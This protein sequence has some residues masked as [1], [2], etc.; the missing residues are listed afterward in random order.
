MKIVP[1]LTAVWICLLTV[2]AAQAQESPYDEPP[3]AEPPYFRIRYMAS[4]EPGKLIFPVAYTVWIPAGV[5]TLRGVVVHQHGCGEGS[6][7]SGQTGAYDLHWQALARKHDCALLSP[8]YEQPEGA[9]CQTWCDPRNGSDTAFQRAL[10]DLGRQ[11]VHEELASVPW[12][13]WGHSGGGHWAGGMLM[14]HPD[15]VA[16][17]WLRSGVPH[18]ERS[19]GRDIKPHSLPGA[20]LSVPVMC[21]LGTKEGVTVTDG[22]FSRVWPT[23]RAFF[24]RMRRRGGLIAVAIDPLTSH[25]C[26]NQRYLAIPWFDACLSARLPQRPDQPLNSIAENEGWVAPLQTGEEKLIAPKP[27]E[28]FI[29]SRDSSIWLPGEAISKAWMQYMK[30]ADVSDDTKP[31]APFDIQRI[32]NALIWSAQADLQ[33]GI[34]H[35]VI[36]RNGNQIA[37]VTGKGEN[38]FGRA[39]FQGLQYSD[40]PTKPL[41]EMRYE[42]KDKSAGKAVDYQI[43]TVNT[44]G[45]I[46]R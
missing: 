33:S 35:F 23:N 30:S 13:L 46:S 32:G 15:R 34:S 6:C 2:L 7:Q 28:K 25:E 44:A 11:S 39:L 10:E 41:A 29:G 45:L 16:A 4:D 17:V 36:E 1:N 27:S 9:D 26:G 40:T 38:R 18:F 19:E 43:H 21:N 3:A 5:E 20:A 22:R 31:P 42:L 37:S 14:L 24:N 12:A 8:S